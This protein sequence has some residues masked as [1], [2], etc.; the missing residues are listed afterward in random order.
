MLSAIFYCYAVCHCDECTYPESDW[1]GTNLT[2]IDLSECSKLFLCSLFT[3]VCNK[4]EYFFLASFSHGCRPY[5]HYTKMERLPWDKHSS[6]IQTF[7][8]YG[9]TQFYNIGSAGFNSQLR[10]QL[11]VQTSWITHS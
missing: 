8:S 5:K 3:N 10:P 1:C 11:A 6:A 2:C 7:V 9:K 4:L